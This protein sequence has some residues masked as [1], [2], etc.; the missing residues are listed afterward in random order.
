MF[1]TRASLATL[2]LA[3]VLAGCSSGG[4]S[5]GGA[6]AAAAGNDGRCDASG[7]DFAI[8]KPGSA[9]LLEQARKASG[10]QMARILKP[11]DVV[12][13]EYRSERLNLNVDERGVVIRANCG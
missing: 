1:R 3:S 9:E 6:P 4:H 13:L 2:L 8:G 7:A 5:G 11:H 12:T 10:S